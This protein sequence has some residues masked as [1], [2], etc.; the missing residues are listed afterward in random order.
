MQ[1][2][3]FPEGS[4]I[5][6]PENL[7]CISSLSGLERAMQ[8]G[9]VLEAA[10]LMC[11]EDF[12][13]V[14]DLGGIKGIMKREDVAVC[15]E[16]DVC[17]DIAVLTRVGKAVCFVVT[18]FL[19]ENGETVCLLSRKR[20][21]EKCFEEYLDL[22][23]DGDVIPAKVTHFENFGCFCDIGCGIS[24]LL[25]IDCISVSRISHPRD[26]FRI[27]QHI[28]AAVRGR[29]E[30][31]LGSRGRICLTH[32]E[33]LGTWE[34][35][36]AA[37]SVGQTVAGIIRGVEDYG[38]FVELAP[39]LAGLAERRP[40]LGPGQTAAVYVKNIIPSKMKIKLVIVDVDPSIRVNTDFEYFITQGNVS[41]WRYQ[42]DCW[43]K[44]KIV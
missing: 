33:L 23:S 35:N 8:S 3:F 24:S 40:D 22:L 28:R 15:R 11:D 4:L 26:R 37:F 12:Q 30:I 17:R 9:K 42:P 38:V 41:G 34:Q 16:G 25:S 43:E 14:F 39:N 21:Q 36:A 18:G 44:R 32:K 10:A 1:E 7:K 2:S 5:D 27:G 13:L 31:I 20:A 19:R 29:D 6:S